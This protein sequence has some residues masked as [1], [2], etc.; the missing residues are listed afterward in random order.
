MGWPCRPPHRGSA[1]LRG[2]RGVH[3]ATCSGLRR[4]TV[5]VSGS[6]PPM[7][8]LGGALKTPGD[9]GPLGVSRRRWDF[10]SAAKEAPCCWLSASLLAATQE[11]TSH[12]LRPQMPGG[13]TRQAFP[14]LCCDVFN[15]GPPPCGREHQDPARSGPVSAGPGHL[16]TSS[17]RPSRT[18]VL[19]GVFHD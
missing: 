10:L 13:R 5:H 15:V 9:S 8:S 19:R 3:R 11:S 4:R 12:P 16:A 7:D 6:W 2:Q 18:L 1:G 14:G 17:P